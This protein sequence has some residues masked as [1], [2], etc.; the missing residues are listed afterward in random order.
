[1]VC[2]NK[3]R[4]VLSEI[5]AITD[6]TF[7]DIGTSSDHNDSWTTVSST[8]D[9]TRAESY[10]TLTRKAD[11]SSFGYLSKTFGLTDFVIEFD[12]QFNQSPSASNVWIM[13]FREGSTTRQAIVY[14]TLAFSDTEW[15]HIKFKGNSQSIAY[16]LDGVKVS[17]LTP[18][19]TFDRFQFECRDLGFELNYKNFVIYPI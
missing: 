15:H 8:I 5:Y 19:G 9:R 12:I 13:S 14:S 16:Y 3:E 4:T 10:T 18:N 1:M 6:G 7:K 2:F 17:D 11:S